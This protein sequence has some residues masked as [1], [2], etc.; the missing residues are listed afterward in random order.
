MSANLTLRG[1]DVDIYL[2]AAKLLAH[3]EP[4]GVEQAEQVER[5]SY[6]CAEFTYGLR[7][8][9]NA[10]FNQKFLDCRVDI[11]GNECPGKII[12]LKQGR[13]FRM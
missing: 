7:R 12:F 1:I 2:P 13:T 3:P 4:P 6:M 8:E 11:L 10:E 9:I 5:M